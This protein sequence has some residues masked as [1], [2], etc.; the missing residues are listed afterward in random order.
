MKN[1]LWFHDHFFPCEIHQHGYTNTICSLETDFQKIDIIK[2]PLY[3]RMVL[4]DGDV[5]SS[6]LDEYIYHETLVLPAMISHPNPKNIYLA[7]GGE[8]AT[9]REILKCNTV[10]SVIKCDIDQKAIQLFM[11]ELPQWHQHSFFDPRVT[12]LHED[13]RANLSS[14]PDGSFDIIYTDLTEPTDGGPSQQLFSDEFFQLCFQKLADNGSI[15]LQASLLRITNHEMHGSILRTIQHSFP[16]VRSMCVYVPSFDTTW[17]FIYASKQIDPLTL[18]HSVIENRI[19][20]RLCSPTRYYDSQIHQSLFT[21]S[22]DLR[23]LLD[24]DQIVIKDDQPFSLKSK[25]EIRA[26]GELG[27]DFQLF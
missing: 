3:G 17:G 26:W 5:Q 12:L 15:C 25:S 11:K 6:Q 2:S 1:W 14:Q 27:Q 8:G 13:A 7:G 24:T 18:E 21:I 16:I 22:K 4:I 19:K 10:T 23:Q 20:E 9:L